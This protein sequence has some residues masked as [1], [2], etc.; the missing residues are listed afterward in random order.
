[1]V[2][3]VSLGFAAPFVQVVLEVHDNPRGER[4]CDEAND[5]S[6]D[7]EKVGMLFHH[8]STGSQAQNNDARKHEDERAESTS[9]IVSVRSDLMSP[10]LDIGVRDH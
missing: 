3:L 9:T 1:M 6:A 4:D 5:R 8:N 10:L 2:S 7:G